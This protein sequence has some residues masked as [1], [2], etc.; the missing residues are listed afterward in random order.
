MWLRYPLLALLIGCATAPPLNLSNATLPAARPRVPQNTH[1]VR[2]VQPGPDVYAILAQPGRSS[3]DRA[4]DRTRQSADMLAYV[5]ARPGQRV[6]V[7]AAGSGHFAELLALSVGPS[8]LVIAQNAPRWTPPWI[9][10]VWQE[11][12]TRPSMANVVARTRDFQS[13]LDPRD[14][15]LDMVYLDAEYG[16]LVALG[17][18]RQAIDHAAHLAL[19]HGGR[20]VVLDRAI[21][22]L[23]S[24]EVA[25]RQESRSTRREIESVG[26]RLASEGRFIRTSSDPRDWD[27]RPDITQPAAEL[28]AMAAHPG[29]E[30]VTPGAKE[31]VFVLVFVKP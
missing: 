4:L 24:P 21:P 14:R 22:G 8:G 29:I 15:D 31:D 30:S 3:A 19:K 9:E 16:T 27:A 28:G 2:E 25:H 6:A 1:V 10:Q 7:L 5:D 23:D 17:I 11:R 13:P 20:Y 12:L 18:D 26:F